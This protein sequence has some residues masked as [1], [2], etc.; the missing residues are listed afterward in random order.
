VIVKDDDPM[1]ASVAEAANTA[2]WEVLVEDFAWPTMDG[3][4]FLTVEDLS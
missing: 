2:M 3:N 4:E 1:F